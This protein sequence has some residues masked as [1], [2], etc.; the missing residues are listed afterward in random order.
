MSRYDAE[1]YVDKAAHIP[2]IEW[3]SFTGGEPMLHP[4]LVEGLVAY[5]SGRGLRTE[6][7]TN[8]SWAASQEK[9]TGTLKRLRDAGLDVLNMS[10]DDF[11][12]AVIPFERVR[13]CYEAAKGLGIKMVIMTALSRSSRIDLGE[14]SRLCEEEVVRPGGSGLPQGSVIGLESGFIPVGR[15]GKIPSS[16]W[17]LDGSP[18]TGGCEAVLRDIGVRPR[19][20]VMP[21]CS[22]S[23]TLPGFSIGNLSDWDLEDLI[24]EAWRSEVFRVLREKGPMGLTEAH[25]GGVYVNKCHLCSEVLRPILASMS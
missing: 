14:V 20:E 4:S 21:C 7:V 23:A 15:G 18:L 10:A 3:V 11:H 24:D 19:G 5:A 22:A 17:R 8:C 2:S 6:L 25:P 13:N 1:D 12:Q 16:E 9:A